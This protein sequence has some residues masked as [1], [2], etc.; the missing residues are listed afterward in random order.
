MLTATVFDIH[1]H[2][3][4]YEFPVTTCW[5]TSFYVFYPRGCI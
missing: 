3:L 1:T 2:P 5:Q 4:C